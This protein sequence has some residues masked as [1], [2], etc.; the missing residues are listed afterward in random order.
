MTVVKQFAWSFSRLKNFEQC[1]LKY[2]QVDVEKRFQDSTEQLDWGNKV[3]EALAS[4]CKSGHPLPTG[5][6]QWAKYVRSIRKFG[7]E[8]LTEQKFALSRNFEPVEYFSPGVWVRAIADLLCIKPPKA[9]SLDWKTGR[10]QIDSKQLMLVAAAVFAHHPDVN[11]IDSG[12]VWLKEDCITTETYTRDTIAQEWAGLLPRVGEL[13]QAMK[14]GHF[15]PKP[16]RLCVKYCPVQ[17]CEFWRKGI[18]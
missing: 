8:I 15:M 2:Q 3:H 7:G 13:E 10:V 9:L 11:T 16:S 17:T 12:Y 5:M 1:P 6:D 14:T 4:A 18:R